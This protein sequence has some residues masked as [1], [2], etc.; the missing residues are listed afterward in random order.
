[1][2]LQEKPLTPC[3]G[4]REHFGA[5]VWA[6]GAQRPSRWS[7]LLRL[8]SPL[9]KTLSR[10][11]REQLW[12]RQNVLLPVLPAQQTLPSHVALSEGRGAREKGHIDAGD[13]VLLRLLGDFVDHH[14]THE[15]NRDASDAV[16]HFLSAWHRGP[17]E[18]RSITG[19]ERRRMFA[20]LGD[21]LLQAH[22]H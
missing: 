18:I 5:T 1:L 4:Q 15:G 21:E 2:D 3:G 9:A 10:W 13:L 11:K 7:R 17:G 19:L 22:R 12:T 8:S 6:Q 20:R 14:L 16:H